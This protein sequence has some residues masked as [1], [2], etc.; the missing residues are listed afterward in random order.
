[1]VTLYRR[2][3]DAITFLKSRIPAPVDKATIRK[4]VRE[5]DDDNF[6]TRDA[7]QNALE[8]MGTAAVAM[9]R[10]TLKDPPSLEAKRRLSVLAGKLTYHD[11]DRIRWLRCAE[12]LERIGTPS[13]R[14]TLE[15]FRDVCDPEVADD[16]TRSLKRLAASTR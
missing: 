15:L 16:A 7:A 6:R 9:V 13:A 2:P 14:D 8:K 4:L 3:D 1:M 5:L 12:L 11:E 10:Q